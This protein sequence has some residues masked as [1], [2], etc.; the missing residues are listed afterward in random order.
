MIAQHYRKGPSSRRD[1][2]RKLDYYA[3]RRAVK[4]H[5]SPEAPASMEMMP[6]H[7]RELPDGTPFMH[8]LE[9]TLHVYYNRST[10]QVT[11]IH[12]TPLSYSVILDGV[13][14]DCTRWSR[15]GFTHSNSVSLNAKASC[16]R[17]MRCAAT[18]SRYPCSMRSLPRR[19]SGEKKSTSMKSC[20]N[21]YVQVY[22]II[23]GHTRD[24]FSAAVP[25]AFV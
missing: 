20:L 18:V 5:E 21:K 16:T 4:V 2:I 23:F 25:P 22:T 6:D 3:I 1:A 14:W 10:I 12:P 24:E 15:T 13:C 17:S 9:P 19:Q 7:L 11:D 8:R